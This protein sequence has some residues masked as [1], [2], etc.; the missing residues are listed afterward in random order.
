MS[1]NDASQA[2]YEVWST[3]SPPFCTKNRVT[4]LGSV[5]LTSPR[6]RVSSGLIQSLRGTGKLRLLQPDYTEKQLIN[7]QLLPVIILLPRGHVSY[8]LIACRISSYL[9]LP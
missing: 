4:S 8:C 7:L 2:S 9:L 6:K 3:L 1:V 5:V